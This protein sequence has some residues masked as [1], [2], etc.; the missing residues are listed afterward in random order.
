MYFECPVS[1]RDLSSPAS[2][3]ALVLQ[4]VGDIGQ[5]VLD[6]V[7]RNTLHLTRWFR[8]STHDPI[9]IGEICGVHVNN[10]LSGDRG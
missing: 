1:H 5:N 7:L 9:G 3:G 6:V 2:K 4:S 10:P 8:A